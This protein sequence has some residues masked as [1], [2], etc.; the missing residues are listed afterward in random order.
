MLADLQA[1]RRFYQ[2]TEDATDVSGA[3]DAGHRARAGEEARTRLS[4]A[5]RALLG[6][7]SPL[8]RKLGLVIDRAGATIWRQL[9][10]A[11][12]IQAD[13]VMRGV[14]Q[15]H[16]QP[17]TSCQVVGQHVHGEVQQRRLRAGHAA[18]RRRSSATPCWT[19]IPT[20]PRSSSNNTRGSCRASSRGEQRRSGDVGACHA[21]GHRLR[22]GPHR[23]GRAAPRPCGRRGRQGRGAAG[24]HAAAAVAGRD[25]PRRTARGVG[26][27]QPRLA[28]AAPAP[29]DRGGRRRRRGAVA[30]SRHRVPAGRRAHQQRHRRRTGRRYAHEVVAGWEGW[31]LSV[32]GPATSSCTRT[33]TRW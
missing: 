15:P 19:S 12:W 28:F 21:A 3:A 30:G 6:D 33:A 22:A 20:P 17:R 14:A 13:V 26:R 32:P 11:A 27:R 2:R 23:S 16:T 8:L 1:A 25:Q 4:R 10:S 7:L 29:A 31:S 18:H 9:A 24:R 5:G